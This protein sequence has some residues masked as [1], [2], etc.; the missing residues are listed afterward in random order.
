MPLLLASAVGCEREPAQEPRV[1]PPARVETASRPSL[2]ASAPIAV[3]PPRAPIDDDVDPASDVVA[4]SNGEDDLP[5][6]PSDEPKEYAK[7]LRERS[8]DERRRI[9]AYCRSVPVDYRYVCGGI[10]PLHIPIPPHPRFDDDDDGSDFKSMKAWEAALS[11]QQRRYYRRYCDHGDLV[12]AGSD[13]CGHDT[14]LVIAFDGEP[15]AFSQGTTFAFAHGAPVTTDWPT[16][17]TPWLALDRDR[18]GTIDSGAELFGDHTPLPGA[19]I[20]V[21]GFVALAAL[22]D[23]GDG[24]ID[25][26]DTAFSALLLWADADADGRSSSGELRA[27]ANTVVSISLR[28]RLEPR[29][30]ERGN[31]EGERA[32]ITWRDATGVARTGAVVDVYLPRR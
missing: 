19:R 22:D 32:Q 1:E 16:A 15:I 12:M 30:D 23:N 31:C 5:M 3:D 24:R 13:L 10:G 6:P 29:C 11:S 8:P 27:A 14:P 20:A 28:Y 26:T 21:N 9:L 4:D 25:A 7:W 18:N 17:S 2:A